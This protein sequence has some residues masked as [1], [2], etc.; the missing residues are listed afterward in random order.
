VAQTITHP[1][2]ED[3]HQHKLQIEVVNQLLLALGEVPLDQSIDDCQRIQ[4][5][6]ESN[7]LKPTDTYKLQ[8][9][10]LAL[11]DVISAKIGLD[12][13]IIE[14]EYGRDPAL[15]YRDTSLI[16]FP[17]TMISKRIERGESVDAKNLLAVTASHVKQLASEVD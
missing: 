15:R 1:T 17:L 7:I 14:D 9:L 8:S 3:L 16:I 5:V 11:G 4:T 13:V 12:W 6:I 10:G 2:S